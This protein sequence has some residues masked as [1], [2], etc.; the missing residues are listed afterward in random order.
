MLL[1]CEDAEERDASAGWLGRDNRASL[2][3]LNEECLELLAQQAHASPGI[4]WLSEPARLWGALD[5]AGRRRASSCLYLILDAGFAQPGHWR[6]GGAQPR[7]PLQPA[8]FSVPA[9]AGVAQ[10]VFTFAWHL[11]RCRATAARLL[12]GMP[13]LAVAQLA[14]H[15]LGQVRTLALTHPHWLQPRWHAN[16]PMWCEFLGAAADG[17]PVRLERAYLR[18]QTLLAAEVRRATAPYP[19]RTMSPLAAQPRPVPERAALQ[20]P[21]PG[22]GQP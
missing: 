21:P 9:A 1:Q 6:G 17:D 22:A 12:L 13:G 8:F 3:E 4:A 20:V 5:A 16:L 15:T 19:A 11:A 7:G 10:A 2:A 18:G 14:R